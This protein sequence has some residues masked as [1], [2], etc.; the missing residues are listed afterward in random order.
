MQCHQKCPVLFRYTAK[1]LV[2]CIFD[3]DRGVATCFAY[4]QAGRGKTN[5]SQLEV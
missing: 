2:E 1:P 4:G 3:T 5:V